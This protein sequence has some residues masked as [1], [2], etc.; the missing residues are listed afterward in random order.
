MSG[1]KLIIRPAAAADLPMLVALYHYLDKTLIDLQPDFFCEAP[2]DQQA[3]L[4]WIAADDADYLL[5]EKDGTVITMTIGSTTATINGEPAEMLA[6]PELINDS[7]LIPV[8]FISE[9]LGMTVDWNEQLKQIN[10]Y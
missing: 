10:I 1:N 7:T 2:R 4:D 3:I 9:N 5:A 6:A 8:R